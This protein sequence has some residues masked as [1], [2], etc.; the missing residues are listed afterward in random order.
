MAGY[1]S[2][3]FTVPGN[4]IEIIVVSGEKSTY[5][6]IGDL[7]TDRRHGVEGDRTCMDKRHTQH[8]T[9]K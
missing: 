4:I 8:L 2:A 1:T 3:V 6:L 9:F 7:G 5:L